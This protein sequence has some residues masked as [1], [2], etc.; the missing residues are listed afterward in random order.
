VK[1]SSTDSL[2]NA[3]LVLLD[4]VVSKKDKL[5]YLL[6][7]TADSLLQ[8]T[9]LNWTSSFESWSHRRGLNWSLDQME[10]EG[11]IERQT[12]KLADRFYALSEKG[13][14]RALRTRDPQKAWER[15]W[16]RI[17]RMVCFDF[18][19]NSRTV[20][21]SVRRYLR[22]HGFG[23]FQKSV[24][25]RSMKRVSASR[26]ALRN[27]APRSIKTRGGWQRRMGKGAEGKVADELNEDACWRTPTSNFQ[28]PTFGPRRG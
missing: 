13:L 3:F 10:R 24:S 27:R 6:L 1:K 18:P 8:P 14:A 25:S 12:D 2:E 17:I 11:L 22:A 19:E 26:S 16:D 4:K 7:W 21:N 23:M 5:L 15:P 28:L 20:R 9:L